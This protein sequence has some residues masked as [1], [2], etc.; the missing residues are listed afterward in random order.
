[1]ACSDKP[2]TKGPQMQQCRDQVKGVAMWWFSF[3]GSRVVVL[4]WW[5]SCGGDGDGVGVA[6]AAAAV[7]VVVV[8]VVAAAAAAVIA[9][10]SCS[11]NRNGHSTYRMPLVVSGAAGR[12][13]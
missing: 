9:V 10:N 13:R 11:I 12:P 2:P 1:M 8:V 7:L 6:A 4:V 3:G 5:F